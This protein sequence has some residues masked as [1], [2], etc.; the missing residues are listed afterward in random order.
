MNWLAHVFL[1]TDSIDFQLGNL[2]SDPLKGRVWRGASEELVAGFRMHAR[3]DSFTDRHEHV[4][5]SK[6]RL[7]KKGYLKPV[8]IDLVYDH[9]LLRHWNLFCRMDADSF[10]T[11]FHRAARPACRDFPD[12]ARRFVFGL[13]DSQHLLSYRTLDGLHAALQR[14]DRRLSPR[15]RARES[16]AGYLPRI[17]AELDGIETDFLDFFPQLIMHFASAGEAVGATHWMQIPHAA[18]SDQDQVIR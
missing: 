15:L 18:D 8:V 7:A 5:R 17:E 3:I 2:L 13:V 14:I 4:R 12:Q 10:V 16:A 1:S 6:S 9:L 11:G